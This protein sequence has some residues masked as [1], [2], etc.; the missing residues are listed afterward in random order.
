MSLIIEARREMS[1]IANEPR[2]S[3]FEAVEPNDERVRE[4]LIASGMRALEQLL[5]QVAP[6]QSGEET[7]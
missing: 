5:E 7:A 2:W 6:I 3:L 4:L 1:R